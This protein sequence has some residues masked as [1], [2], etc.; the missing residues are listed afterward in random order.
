MTLSLWTAPNS[1]SVSLP[2]TEAGPVHAGCQRQESVTVTLWVI[3]GVVFAGLSKAGSGPW[4]GAMEP[5]WGREA[6]W[7]PQVPQTRASGLV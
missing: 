3:L 2:R 7:G 4:E 6:G 5:A 1:R